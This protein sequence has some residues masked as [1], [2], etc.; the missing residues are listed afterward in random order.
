MES[1]PDDPERLRIFILQATYGQAMLSAH[2]LE[3]KVASL[4]VAKLQEKRAKGVE[5]DLAI[6]KINR[7]T[8]GP[9]IERF[10]AEFAV[11]DELQEELDNMLYFRNELTHR[12]SDMVLRKGAKVDWQERLLKELV[13]IDSYFRETSG[14]LNKYVDQW[15][16]G[17]GLSRRKLVEIAFKLYPGF[18]PGGVRG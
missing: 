13:E 15:L 12:I 5:L 2:A 3:R 7:L 9:L 16:E 8:F 18:S 11:D 4:L 1:V 6:E 14:M 10:V 17:V